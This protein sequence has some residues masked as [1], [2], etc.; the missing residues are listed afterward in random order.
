MKK[1]IIYCI[2]ICLFFLMIY[3][4][5]YISFNQTIYYLNYYNFFGKYKSE[6]INETILEN[7]LIDKNQKIEDIKQISINYTQG[8]GYLLTYK[9]TN[10][11]IGYSHWTENPNIYIDYIIS[12]NGYNGPL[13]YD[14][15]YIVIKYII[16]VMIIIPFI[17]LFIYLLQR[18]KNLIQKRES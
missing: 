2:Y 13:I 6:L 9:Y 14:K 17:K 18:I 3:L 1:W 5:F 8:Y 16:I 10:R 15:Y 4:E 11:D 7:G 12:N